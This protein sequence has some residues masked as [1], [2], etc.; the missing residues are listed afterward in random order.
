MNPE[1][2]KPPTT[3]TESTS[4]DTLPAA[5]GSISQGMKGELQSW[6]RDAVAEARWLFTTKEGLIG[7]YEFVLPNMFRR[8]RTGI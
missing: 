1:E 2:E 5:P 6:F 8:H 4:S 7:N 3:I